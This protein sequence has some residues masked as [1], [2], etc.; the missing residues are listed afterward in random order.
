MSRTFSFI[1]FPSLALVAISLTACAGP[2]PMTAAKQEA[3]RAF[4]YGQY[5]KAVVGYAEILE[6]APGDWQVEYRYGVSLAEV[7]NLAEAGPNLL[8]VDDPIVTIACC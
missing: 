1:A 3:D 6:R 4:Q 5:D 7:G 8:A 2:R